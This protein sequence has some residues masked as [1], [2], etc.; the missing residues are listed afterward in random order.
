MIA[1][2][3]PWSDCDQ[4]LIEASPTLYQDNP[5]KRHQKDGIILDFNEAW[6]DG[7]VVAS[8]G[9]YADDLHFAVDRWPHKHLITQ[10][11]QARCRS[12]FQA[13]AQQCLNTEGKSSITKIGKYT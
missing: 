10:F 11:S 1:E 2:Y 8:D 5:C 13:M 12:W 6:D 9:P 4:M 7:V 3:F